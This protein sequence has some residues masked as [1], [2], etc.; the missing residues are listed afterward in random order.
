MES[1]TYQPTQ[2]SDP[3]VEPGL[4]FSN[5]FHADCIMV[6][7]DG[8][9][10]SSVIAQLVKR[11][12]KNGRLC[13]SQDD[14]VAHR[15]KYRESLAS[16]AFGRGLAF[17]H[18]RTPYVDDFIGA[19]GILPSGISFDSNDGAKTKLV[20][21]TLSPYASRQHHT[22]LL[23]RLVSLLSNKAA[24]VRLLH[25]VNPTVFHRILCSFDSM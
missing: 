20:F 7:G 16:T 2:S 23:S 10:K 5:V 13:P 8:E 6:L 9:T 15:I 1:S 22:Q 25:N 24:A 11:L 12:A 21:L 19:I 18:L 3:A 17:P 4:S 14:F